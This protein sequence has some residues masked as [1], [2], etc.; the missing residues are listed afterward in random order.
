MV[1]MV[2]IAIMMIAMMMVIIDDTRNHNDQDYRIVMA[3]KMI[4]MILMILM[5]STTMAT[6]MVMVVIALR[7]NEDKS[8]E[9]RCGCALERKRKAERKWWRELERYRSGREYYTKLE[10]I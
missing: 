3:M 10:V 8:R 2:M 4:Q 5:V 1:M 9:N 6:M 7:R